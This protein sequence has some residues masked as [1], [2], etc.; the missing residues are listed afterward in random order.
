VTALD[1]LLDGIAVL[2]TPTNLAAVAVGVLLGTL[3]G[4]L[5]GIGPLGAMALLLVGTSDLRPETALI[6]LAGVYYG[7]AYGG[8]TTSILMGIPGEAASVV[9]AIDGHRMALRGRAGA[10]LTVAAVG[11]FVAGTIA[12]VGVMLF[13][14]T[15]AAWGVALG[16][17]EYFAMALLGLFALSRLGGNT[18]AQGLLILGFGLALA[19]IGLDPVGGVTRFTFG[20]DALLQGIGLVPVAIGLFGIPELLEIAERGAKA[21]RVRSVRWRELFPTRREW[22]RS[23][24]AISRGTVVGFLAGILP[25]PLPVVSTFASWKLEKRLSRH[26]EEFGQGAIEG[27]AGPESANNAATTGQM[28]PVL[29]LGVPFG[30]ATAILL[31]ALL[32]QGIQPGPQLLTVHPDIFWAVIASMYVGNLALLVLNLPLVGLWVRILRLPAGVLLA[33]VVLFVMVGTFADGNSTTD[34]VVMLALGAIS[35]LLRKVGLDVTPIILAIVL[36]A[37][38]E[39]SMRQSLFMSRGDLAVFVERPATLALLLVTA[40]V[41]VAPALRRL[42][43]PSVRSRTGPPAIGAAEDRSSSIGRRSR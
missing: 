8:S 30:P 33:L 13:A 38:L 24:P 4:V 39:N 36:G 5:P 29:A 17:P 35:Y 43:R 9:T 34:L 20:L 25:G 16:P 14:P 32:L 42:V 11:S 15:L 12:V 27:V 31:S 2:V 41:V 6:L 28:V 7:S 37:I 23:I 18:T 26:P 3:V 21:E 1:G 22:R 10:A 40:I 19:T